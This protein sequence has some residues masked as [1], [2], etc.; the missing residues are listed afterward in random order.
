MG[1]CGTIPLGGASE[2]S[3]QVVHCCVLFG[4]DPTSFSF[5]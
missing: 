1:P 2:G 5:D 3:P 4:Q